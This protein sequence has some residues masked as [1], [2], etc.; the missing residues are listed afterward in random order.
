M[1]KHGYAVEE[2]N[3]PPRFRA[4]GPVFVVIKRTI[5]ARCGDREVAEQIAS[6]LRSNEED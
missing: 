3:I 6:A 5:L 1:V 2:V 4:K